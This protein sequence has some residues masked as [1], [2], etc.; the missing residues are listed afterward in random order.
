MIA[1]EALLG[2]LL[3]DPPIADEV[4]TIV[5]PDDFSDPSRRLVYNA[6][7][8]CLDSMGTFDIVL[9]A[10]Q[11]KGGPNG[12]QFLTGLTDKCPSPHNWRAYAF[13]V[14][15]DA[16][17]R[18]IAMI[19]DETKQDLARYAVDEVLDKALSRLDHLRVG[20]GVG[21]TDGFDELAVEALNDFNEAVAS[22]ALIRGLTFGL[23]RIDTAVG[24]LRPGQ[25]VM[26]L[27]NTNQG[28][29]TFATT[30]AAHMMTEEPGIIGSTESQPKAWLNKLVAVLTKISFDRIISGFVTSEQAEEIRETYNYIMTSGSR[31]IDD[32][33]PSPETI[34]AHFRRGKS[35]K[36]FGWILIDSATKMSAPGITD[37]YYRYLYIAD[38][39]QNLA[40]ELQV[41]I[42]IT[43]QVKPEVTRRENKLPV[44]EDVMGGAPLANNADV[45]ISL[46]NHQYYVDRGMAKPH[47]QLIA[48]VVLAQIVKH[49]WRPADRRAGALLQFLGGAGFYEP[50]GDAS[51]IEGISLGHGV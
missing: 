13:Q 4:R 14:R 51:S 37:V 21:G 6:M 31:I 9:L 23:P 19:A 29:S 12:L 43:S 32:G 45:I 22:P 26:I 8:E 48:G 44:S 33:S 16:M 41:P 17:I 11:L 24:G 1:E 42:V 27:G 36:K 18:A 2:A 47:P 39:L 49:R 46:L 40:R 15:G 7:L 5:K 28:K 30:G 50:A 34:G 10:E 38:G 25:L 3:F 20:V 35:K